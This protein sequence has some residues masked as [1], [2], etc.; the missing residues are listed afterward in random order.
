VM[1]MFVSVDISHNV[2]G[3]IELLVLVRMKR[4]SKAIAGEQLLD[5]YDVLCLALTP[6]YKFCVALTSL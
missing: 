4:T 6:G 1:R 2:T 5:L 3:P